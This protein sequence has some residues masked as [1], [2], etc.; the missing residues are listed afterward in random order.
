M[1]ERNRDVVMGLDLSFLPR[2]GLRHWTKGDL[3]SPAREEP[4]GD[5]ISRKYTRGFDGNESKNDISRRLQYL[6]N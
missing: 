6:E 4:E 3:F 2:E 1:F 5:L